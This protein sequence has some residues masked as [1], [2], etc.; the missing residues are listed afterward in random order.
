MIVVSINRDYSTGIAARSVRAYVR[1]HGYRLH[2]Q[3]KWR[4]PPAP[5]KDP[6]LA[7]T[8]KLLA[9]SEFASGEK[10]VLVIDSDVVISPWTPPIDTAVGEFVGNKIGIV[11]QDQPSMDIADKIFKL[12]L[13]EPFPKAEKYYSIFGDDF[14]NIGHG[15]L[16][17]GVLLLQPEQGHCYMLKN[18]YNSKRARIYWSKYH[19]HYDQPVL[20]SMLL[21]AGNYKRLDHA[22][23]RGWTMYHHAHRVG[24]KR[25][26]LE[27]VFRK[28][29]FMHLYW[30]KGDTHV[31][32]ELMKRKNITFDP[33]PYAKDLEL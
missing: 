27:Q 7:R 29:Y 9:C 26:T 18:L 12:R 33:K 11:D 22:W 17:S 14:R 6:R 23:N 3:K 13:K 5:S 31:L 20:G 32:D 25:Y 19:D 30:D 21:R 1:R 24:G 4:G 10:Y 28:S 8:Q 15:I 2:V 16:N